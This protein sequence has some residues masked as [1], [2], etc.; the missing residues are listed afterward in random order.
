MEGNTSIQKEVNE[1]VDIPDRRSELP[2]YDTGVVAC[3]R[4]ATCRSSTASGANIALLQV[5]VNF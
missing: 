3:S 4:P 2:G 5:H 1:D